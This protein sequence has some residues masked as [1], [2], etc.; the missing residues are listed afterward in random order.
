V[1]EK[2]LPRYPVYIP[3]KGRSR[4]CQTAKALDRDGVPF[5]L[6]VEPQEFDGYAARFGP[7]RLISLPWSGDDDRRREFCAARGIENGGLIAVRNWI[8]EHSVADGYERHWQ[9]DDNIHCF[10]RRWQA[11]RLPCRAGIALRVCEDFVDRYENVA[12]A[13]LNYAMFARE[14]MQYPPF[15]LNVHV[16]SCTLILNRI[17][18]RWRLRYNDD[19]DI[20]L[21]VL[22]D[23]WC[24]VL[25]NAF[26][27]QK[28]VTMA[29]KGGNTTDLYQGDGR[30]KMAR[31][32]ERR[33]PGVV[34]T[35][36][37]WKR[38]QHV[39]KDQW[40]HFNTPLKPKA[41]LTLAGLSPNEYGMTLRTVRPVQSE[42]LRR[43]I[44]VAG[45]NADGCGP[46]TEQG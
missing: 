1:P 39:V 26:V 34:T 35:D 18:H 32:L 37:R 2:T 15:F 11:Q 44:S 21:Q 16:Y 46:A 19:T 12:V 22:A 31:E 20:C 27:A 38:P 25:L 5:R 13:G 9:I 45:A 3:S 17:P 43:L 14:R 42:T 24:T 7:D 23:G 30:L 40:R 4:Y 10:Y 33:W 8:K 28:I 41:G 29:I 36:R 6:V